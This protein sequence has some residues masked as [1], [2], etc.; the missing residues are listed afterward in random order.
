M[1]FLKELKKE[2]QKTMSNKEAKDYIKELQD[3]LGI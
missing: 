1:N 2:L 3:K